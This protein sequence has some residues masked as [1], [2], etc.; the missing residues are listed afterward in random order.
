MLRA[1]GVV[2]DAGDDSL[3]ISGLAGRVPGG[4]DTAVE[5]QL[6]HRV[7]MAAL[8]LGLAAEKPVMIDDDAPIATSFPGFVETHDGAGR[9]DRGTAKP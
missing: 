3:A 8:V 4:N 9:T 5:T 2:A 1:T 6:D 7:A